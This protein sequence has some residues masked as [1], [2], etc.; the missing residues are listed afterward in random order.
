MDSSDMLTHS[1][2]LIDLSI[3]GEKN[4]AFV[5]NGILFIFF[6]STYTSRSSSCPH[7]ILQSIE[8]LFFDDGKNAYIVG[9]LVGYVVD[10]I[11]ARVER[12]VQRDFDRSGIEM[13]RSKRERALIGLVACL[14]LFAVPIGRINS[15]RVVMKMH[16]I[17]FGRKVRRRNCRWKI[18]IEPHGRPSPGEWNGIRAHFFFY[19]PIQFRRR[20]GGTE[21]IALERLVW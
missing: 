13:M 14:A 1:Y 16:V 12:P 18:M 7:I 3:I 21:K 9:V 6:H 4:N 17:N 8:R 20:T 11:R 10:M 15:S 2:L 5:S 19:S